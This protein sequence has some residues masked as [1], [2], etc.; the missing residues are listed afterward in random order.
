MFGHAMLVVPVESTKLTEDIYLPNGSWYRLSSDELYKGEQIVNVPASLTDLPVFV[1]AGSII[2]MQSIVQSINDKGDGILQV[3]IWHGNEANSFVYYEDDGVS[4]DYEQ[5]VY[6]K[7]IISFDP[8]NK[9]ISLSAV[10]GAFKSRFMQLKFVLHGFEVVR[11][12]DEMI[13]NESGEIEVKL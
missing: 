8:V 12:K 2:P 3:H 1:K 7:R 6:Y 10:E 13:G 4:Y 11:L 5:D 9:S